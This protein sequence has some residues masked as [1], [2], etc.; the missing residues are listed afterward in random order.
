MPAGLP[1]IFPRILVASAFLAVLGVLAT[2]GAE[3][4]KVDE[5]LSS[6][7]EDSAAGRF[8]AAIIHL[9][10]AVQTDPENAE[11]R[12]RLGE[13][14]LKLYAI[15]PAEKELR[16]ARNLGDSSPGLR[17]ALARAQLLLGSFDQVVAL[18]DTDREPAPGVEDDLAILRAQALLGLGQ[19]Q[20]AVALLDRVMERGDNAAALEAMAR[21]DIGAGRVEPAMSKARRAYE[22]D[23]DNSDTASTF[24]KLLV[25]ERS[26]EEAY[27]V[28]EPVVADE[29]FRPDTTVLHSSLALELRRFEEARESLSAMPRQIAQTPAVLNLKALLSLHD[30]DYEGALTQAEQAI[31]QSE[32]YVAAQRTA[33]FASLVLGKTERGREYLSTYVT[34]VPQDQD[35]LLRLAWAEAQLGNIERAHEILNRRVFAES[36]SETY[37]R[38]AAEIA[39]RNGKSAEAQAFME[40]YVAL[41][42]DDIE[43]RSSLGLLQFA[44]GEQEVALQAL[45][46]AA[47]EAPESVNNMV[48]LGMAQLGAQDYKAA[49]A[50]AKEIQERFPDQPIGFNLEGAVHLGRGES[51]PARLS[52]EKALEVDP[53]NIPAAI[54]LAQLHV[55]A[56]Q[57]AEAR[58]HLDTILQSQSENVQALLMLA[59]VEVAEGQME[60]AENLIASAVEAGVDSP[61]PNLVQARFYLAT[62]RPLDARKAVVPAV[63]G[64]PETPAVWETDALVQ[65]SAGDFSGAVRAYRQLAR[66]QPENPQPH[67]SAAEALLR[68]R[69]LR[70][71]I[72]ELRS[73]LKRDAAY[74][75]AR[76]GLVRLMV[77]DNQFE[78]AF[79]E[80][81]GLS[82]EMP[83][84]ARVAELKAFYHLRAEE[85]VAAAERELRRAFDLEPSGVRA[86]QLSQLLWSQGE[87]QQA[88]ASLDRWLEQQPDDTQ[89]QDLRAQYHI[90]EGRYGES[91]ASYQRLVEAQPDN[92]AYRNNLA[93]ALWKEGQVDLAKG[94]AQRALELAPESGEIM[95]TLA[96]ILLDLGES[97]R[98]LTLLEQAVERVPRNPDIRVH[99]A[100]ALMVAGE[101][102]RA[103]E[104]L[105]SVLTEYGEFSERAVAEQLLES[106]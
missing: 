1:L 89:I 90:F 31:G 38:L 58:G 102:E 12:R 45:Q 94:E 79:A 46:D 78:S 83:E 4:K 54:S 47:A 17:V 93:W 95:D 88:L 59:R 19:E 37:L 77:L 56:D 28:L 26:L 32:D 43:A 101:T 21:I 51:E 36:Q 48:R 91:R 97:E 81:S 69:R 40:R 16:R 65:A 22:L 5:Y 74:E 11:A 52:M 96:V 2:P 24:A 103:R 76:F 63:E 106:Q 44:Q 3:A 8:E 99:Y 75:P 98:A 35:A 42:P 41:R 60:A 82:D 85:D 10:N 71:A 18:T 55:A 25:Q 14:Y 27:Q 23:P 86:G 84:D 39:L 80:L 53:K 9:K 66:L 73:A 7:E 64:Y 30:G 49:L 87:R 92:P 104:M 50:S 105:K 67:V 57:M 100:Q 72:S 33:G 70:E 61:V 6:A 20:E 62:G 68:D 13:L 29:P 34:R 15:Q